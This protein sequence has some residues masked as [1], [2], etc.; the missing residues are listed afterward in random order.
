MAMERLEM[1]Q[2][3][4]IL[5]LRWQEGL[6]VRQAASSVG[7]SVGSAQ[8]A[9][10]R[11]RKAGLMNWAAVEG[12]DDATL[13]LR[14]Y[15][16]PVV[17]SPERPRPDPVYIHKELRRVGVTLQLLHLEYLEEHPDGLQ[18]TAFCDAY[19]KWHRTAGV[20]MRQTHRAGEK[21]FVDYSGNKPH[22]VKPT[23]GECVY[24]ELFVAVLGASNYTYAE[25]T[26]TQRVPDFI[27]AHVH[28][29]HYFQGVTVITVPDQLK[30]GV[31]R[32]CRYEP[33]IQRTYAEMA[34]HFGTTIVPARPYKAR[35]KAKVEVAVQIAQRWILARLR[36]ETF[37]SLEALNVRIAEL[38]QELNA[39]PM[40]KLGG[41][42]RRELFEK[43]DRPALRPLPAT[44]HEMRQWD[45]VRVNLDYHVEFEKHWYSA[46]YVLVHEQ[47]WACVTSATV[48]LFHRG[49]RVASHVRS[50]V[51][52][53]HTTDPAHMP[54]AHRHYSLGV[55]GVLGWAVKVGPM[56]E[57]FVRRLLESNPVQ[58]MG[59]RSA[60]GLQRVGERHGAERTEQACARA[61]RLGARSYKPVE[62]ILALGRE[63]MPLPGDE[64]PEAPII[65]HQNV[66]GPSY[67]H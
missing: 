36:N 19:R 37:F 15:G 18:Y 64:P 7:R 58:E 33:G 23:T 26:A 25:A 57:A 65:E 3:R 5:R 43:Y 13:E 27:G 45:Q 14:L 59:W 55:E 34:Q 46:P 66:R 28:A 44:A 51:A 9:V 29:Y 53:K 1:R 48:E 56:T 11:A 61:L 10:A 50:P 47:L 8:Q 6:T 20:V 35:D 52:Y 60:R 63:R 2:V 21:T 32:A 38:V 49:K 12:L 40:R 22:Y 39:R 4:E 16:P 62:R 41:A 67:Y 54:D 42:S 31:M 17:V 30:S 24:V